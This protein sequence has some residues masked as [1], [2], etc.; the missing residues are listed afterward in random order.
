VASPGEIHVDVL[1]PAITVLDPKPGQIVVI[2]YECRVGE[3]EPDEIDRAQANLRT[4]QATWP[5][6]TFV[7]L[8]G[9]VELSTHDCGP[10]HVV[11]LNAAHRL[12]EAN[13]KHLR[14]QWRG[15]LG[16]EVADRTVILEPPLA[17]RSVRCPRCSTV[18]PGPDAVDE[19]A[20]GP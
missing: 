11:V 14:E 18:C 5:D 16:D 15:L 8:C 10:G 1:V 20:S 3:M 12:D 2:R 9:D 7:V 6:T 17:V 4:L 19:E 13:W